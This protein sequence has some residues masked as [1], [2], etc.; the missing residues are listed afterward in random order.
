MRMKTKFLLTVVVVLA[1]VVSFSG[2]AENQ[3]GKLPAIKVEFSHYNVNETHLL[4][5]KKVENVSIDRSEAPKL[6]KEQPPFPGIHVFAY[7]GL[8]RTPITYLP[9]DKE[10]DN[11]T[12]YIGFAKPESVPSKG[13][14]LRVVVDIVNQKGDSL[15][16]RN[17]QVTWNMETESLNFK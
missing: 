8:E 4:E 5:I 10:G 1:V 17:R 13:E 12:T 9:L 2:C 7:N 16:T 11:I 3:Q 6:Y 14:K 15:S